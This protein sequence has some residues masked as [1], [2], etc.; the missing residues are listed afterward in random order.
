MTDRAGSPIS[1]LSW[2]TGLFVRRCGRPSGNG[3]G[4]AYLVTNPSRPELAALRKPGHG[5]PLVFL[6]KEGKV[7]K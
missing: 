1:M 6:R 3:P 7:E 4:C 2:M 5:F